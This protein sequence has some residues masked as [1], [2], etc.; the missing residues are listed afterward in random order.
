M[1]QIQALYWALNY[2][3]AIKILPR[4]IQ[5]ICED[6]KSRLYKTYG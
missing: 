1:T 6:L 2:V 4:D 5:V 3:I